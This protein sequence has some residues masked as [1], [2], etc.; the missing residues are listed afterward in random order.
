M[1][2]SGKRWRRLFGGLLLTAPGALV[3]A[4]F[5]SLD[6]DRAAPVAYAG[7]ALVGG[8]ALWLLGLLARRLPQI[9][10][11]FRAF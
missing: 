6:Q 7:A 10:S 8:A 3:A 1:T 11:S 9:F 2:D 4:R 5:I